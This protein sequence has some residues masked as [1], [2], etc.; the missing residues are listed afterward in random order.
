MKEANELERIIWIHNTIKTGSLSKEDYLFKFGGKKERSFYRDL[1]KL[2]N[3]FHAPVQKMKGKYVY[4]DKTFE[5][6]QMLVS[7]KELAALFSAL[8]IVKRYKDTPIYSV[9]KRIVQ[10]LADD[11]IL[12]E[13]FGYNIGN[14]N[15]KEIALD[16]DIFNRIA[17]A[18]INNKTIIIDYHS[19]NSR[20]RSERKVDPYHL[21][22]YEEEIYLAAYCHKNKEIRDF[23]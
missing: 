4:T 15:K 10:K 22:T 23:N 1:T 11:S 9:T 14:L 7:Q 18:I 16:W 8:S 5:L 3:Y 13:L 6:P 17:E 2:Q 19:L 20:E 21:Y 12:N